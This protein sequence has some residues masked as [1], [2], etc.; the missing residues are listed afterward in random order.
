LPKIL[1]RGGIF[2][3]GLKSIMISK[4]IFVL[5]FVFLG[6]SQGQDYLEGGYVSS[7]DYGD[8]R[9]Y[10]T[11]PIFSSSGP[12]NYVSP[13]PAVRQMQESLDRSGRYARIGIGSADTR[14]TAPRTTAVVA[15]TGKLPTNAVGAWYIE[16]ADGTAIDLLLD[17]S[18]PIV[19]GRGRIALFSNVQWATVSGTFSGSSLKLNVVPASGAE[20]YALSLKIS[21]QPPTASYLV[22]KTGSSVRPGTARQVSWTP[23]SI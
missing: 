9:Q 5:L 4:T 12:S 7:G 11:D 14:T 15:G 23:M 18:G 16:L 22:Y 19:F 10:F 8:I 1:S 17:Q 2:I 20:L 13:D 6:L 21:R 3:S